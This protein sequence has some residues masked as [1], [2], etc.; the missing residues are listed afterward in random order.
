MTEDTLTGW[1][2]MLLYG[3]LFAGCVAFWWLAIV[4]VS[5]WIR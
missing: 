5:G 4:T 2:L 3:W 1:R